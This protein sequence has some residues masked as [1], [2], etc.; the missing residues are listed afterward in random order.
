M[1]C[2]QPMLAHRLNGFSARSSKHKQTQGRSIFLLPP[3]FLLLLLLLFSRR[4][5]FRF[6]LS[7][8]SLCLLRREEALTTI[9]LVNT[10]TAGNLFNWWWIK[11][12]PL[13]DKWRVKRASFFYHFSVHLEPEDKI[14]SKLINNRPKRL[15]KFHIYPT[16]SCVICRET[17]YRVV[18]KRETGC[19]D[20]RFVRRHHLS[21]S[22]RKTWVSLC[23]AQCVSCVQCLNGYPWS[24]KK[25]RRKETTEKE[26]ERAK[27]ED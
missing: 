17:L 10:C 27:K 4:L 1:G 6:F 11:R 5:F 25:R 8:S 7:T 2:M 14:L 16:V 18:G 9:S 3:L 24:R 15:S 12:Q 23:I 21:E 20:Y 13:R 26:K 19:R 22:S